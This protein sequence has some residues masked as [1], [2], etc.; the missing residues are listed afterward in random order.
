MK[1]FTKLLK[2]AEKLRSETGCPWDKS[3]TLENMSEPIM[4]EAK[5]VEEAF[6]KR[7][8]DNLKEELGDVLF[9]IVLIAQIAKENK[10]FS[11]EDILTGVDKKIR[12][13][14]TWVFGKDKAK[15]A[16]EA[17]AMWKINKKKEKNVDSR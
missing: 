1:Q 12:E 13:R 11:I 9:N 3:R 8:Y 6:L 5:E 16:E 7:D 17:L 2:L 14:H 15:T 4:N 10:K